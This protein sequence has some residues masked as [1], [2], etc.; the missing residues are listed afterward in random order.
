MSDQTLSGFP[1]SLQ[2]QRLFELVGSKGSGNHFLLRIQGKVNPDLIQ[3]WIS[4]YLKEEENLH[5]SFLHHPLSK[6]PLQHV[7]DN[8]RVLVNF[9]QCPNEMESQKQI[10]ELEQIPFQES[11]TESLRLDVFDWNGS[12]YLMLVNCSRFFSDFQSF[13]NLFRHFADFIHTGQFLREKSDDQLQYIDYSEWQ[14]ELLHDRTQ[15][16]IQYWGKLGLD[17]DQFATLHKHS[18]DW[19]PTE[20]LSQTVAAAP[21]LIESI[22]ALSEAKALQL[23]SVLMAI[24]WQ[25]LKTYTS[26][27]FSLTYNHPGRSE[28]QTEL[29]F[30]LFEKNLPLPAAMAEDEISIWELAK[31]IE[32]VLKEQHLRQEYFHLGLDQTSGK[33]ILYPYQFAW[34]EWPNLDREIRKAVVIDSFSIHP[35]TFHLKMEATGSETIANLSLVIHYN[36]G[37]FQESWIQSLAEQFI[38]Q[39]ELI[40]IQEQ[41]GAAR[42]KEEKSKRALAFQKQIACPNHPVNPALHLVDLLHQALEQ[43]PEKKALT[44]NKNSLTYRELHRLSNQV[45]HYIQAKTG[46]V[47]GA[48]IALQMGNPVHMVVSFIAVLKSGNAFLPIEASNPPL[49]IKYLIE[50]SQAALFFSDQDFAKTEFPAIHS[51]WTEIEEALPLYPTSAPDNV[52]NPDFPCYLIFTSG[53]TGNPKGVPITHGALVN[54]LT[55]F[56]KQSNITDI[57]KTVLFS[58]MAFDLGHT[59]IWSALTTGAHLHLINQTQNLEFLE[60]INSFLTDHEISY[61]KCTPSHFKLIIGDAN[62]PVL[63]DR[64]NLRL[65]VL[66]GEPIDVNDLAQYFNHRKAVTIVDEY[67]PT[68]TTIGVVAQEITPLNFDEYSR[69]PV[70]GRPFANHRVF[71]LDEERNPVLPGIYG[72][73]YVAGP[74]L[75]QGYLNLPELNEKAFVSLS[76]DPGIETRCYATGDL[77]RWLPDGTIQLAGRIDNQVKVRGYRVEPEEI[78]QVIRGFKGVKAVFTNI[79]APGKEEAG[80]RSFVV[81]GEPETSL[82]SL[83]TY[84]LERLPKYMV[85]D[86]IFMVE[87]IQLNANGKVDQALMNKW[88]DD[89]LRQETLQ[90]PIEQDEMVIA[91]IWADLFEVDQIGMQQNFFQ[92]G[93]HSL[94]A[95]KMLSRLQKHLGV[96]VSLSDFFQSPTVQS[97]VNFVRAS[98]QQQIEAI[99]RISQHSETGYFD[100]SLAQQRIWMQEQLKE[101]DGAFNIYFACLIKGDLEIAKLEACLDFLVRRHDSFRT[102]FVRIQGEIRQRITEPEKAVFKLDQSDQHLYKPEE[103]EALILEKCKESFDLEKDA[104]FRCILLRTIDFNPVLVFNFHH[105][106]MDEW[107]MDLFIQELTTLLT[108]HVEIKEGYFP[109]LPIQYKD[110]AAWERIQFSEDRL[111]Q[112]QLFFRTQF[113]GELPVLNL[114][115]DFSRPQKRSFEGSNLVFELSEEQHKQV[116]NFCQAQETSLFVF[117]L[118]MTKALMFRLTNQVDLILGTLEANRNHPDLENIIGCFFNI[119]P[120]RT[121]IKKEV[122]F[123]ELL[124]QVKNQFNATLAYALYPFDYLLRDLKVHQKPGRSPIFDV[125]VTVKTDDKPRTQEVET[126]GIELEE[127]ALPALYSKYDLL[128]DYVKEENSLRIIIE[129]D[130]NL[131][132]PTTIQ[133]YFQLFQIIL[134]AVLQ[135]PSVRLNMIGSALQPID[136]AE[137]ITETFFNF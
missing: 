116:M 87:A 127:F 129:Y 54:Y 46:G 32:S 126:S 98:H 135:N 66:G 15:Q 6:Y 69:L 5:T 8:L 25:L 71:I 89:Q 123:P 112:M 99:Q 63:A 26:R 64:Q 29:I 40:L 120:I 55:W 50:N 49:R 7:G 103:L 133:E 82:T 62:F 22:R 45:A 104:L 20:I 80:L 81:T 61:I 83:K 36:P 10:T 18:G 79:H 95:M 11:L 118:A 48:I 30:G 44:Y 91:Q 115:T 33:G 23:R 94:L 96:R 28:G 86:Q 93:G 85:P 12:E 38:W 134:D 76:F 130:T 125:M 101:K 67:G 14:H 56:I 77:G 128:F 39:L 72:A 111:R 114:K 117:F 52:V 47:S 108:Q 3:N 106:I 100:L 73:I 35:D 24:W 2:Q 60:H 13:A 57:D 53:T 37:V 78:S 102:N 17:A 131:F 90:L 34:R 65:I 4:A 58:S 137:E 107:S 121:R 1:A 122:T 97:L 84:L 27:P 42:W 59:I 75:S 16:Q 74:G 43:H 124:E 119:I 105:I 92:L 9:H 31:N 21:E 109:S 113:G 70:I 19:E 132:L 136:K 88:A 51:S 41:W 110:F 68:E